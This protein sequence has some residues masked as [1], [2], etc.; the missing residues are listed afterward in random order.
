[1][2]N[3]LEYMRIRE[4]WEYS[5]F[6]LITDKMT[7]LWENTKESGCSYRRVAFIKSKWLNNIAVEFVDCRLN[8]SKQIMSFLAINNMSS[9]KGMMELYNDLVT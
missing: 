7:D 3:I 4:T 6:F 2:S 9:V 1:M 8:V 5:Y